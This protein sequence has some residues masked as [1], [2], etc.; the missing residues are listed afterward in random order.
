[1]FYS[2]FKNPLP[3]QKALQTLFAEFGNASFCLLVTLLSFGMRFGEKL[4]GI[5][6][7]LLFQGFREEVAMGKGE[8]L[9]YDV[10]ERET[11]ASM[12][13]AYTSVTFQPF[14]AKHGGAQD[15]MTDVGMWSMA[16]DAG[17]IGLADADVVKHG[18]LLH[19]LE[20]DGEGGV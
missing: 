8:V 1:M 19:K 10:V 15:A 6:D 14:S 3:F 2:L 4:V 7:E 11:G 13:L 9:T 17:G 5:A 20:V 12:T 16:V 18:G